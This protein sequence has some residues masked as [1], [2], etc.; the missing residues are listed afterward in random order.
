MGGDMAQISF[1]VIE[2]T[3]VSRGPHQLQC[4]LK[5]LIF[6]V[7]L[8]QNMA[9]ISDVPARHLMKCL[10]VFLL[11]PSL[12]YTGYAQKYLPNDPENTL[13]LATLIDVS[14]YFLLD[15][16]R[17]PQKSPVDVLFVYILSAI[18]PGGCGSKLR[19]PQ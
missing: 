9:D 13:K 11:D 8:L 6:D 2:A 12:I 14:G 17:K 18:R 19:T 1:H 4:Q 5:I 7:F 10:R 3:C 15:L 16:Q